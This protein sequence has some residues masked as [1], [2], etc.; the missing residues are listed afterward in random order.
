MSAIK[1][2]YIQLQESVCLACNKTV[3]YNSMYCSYKCANSH[4]SQLEMQM[5]VEYSSKIGTLNNGSGDRV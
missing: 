3:S 4:Q 1:N 5:E 2:M